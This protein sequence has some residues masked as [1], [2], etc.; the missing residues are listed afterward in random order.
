MCPSPDHFIGDE[1]KRTMASAQMLHKFDPAEHPGN[2]YDAFCEYVE[3]FAYE[4]EAIAKAP[5]AGTTDVAGW[6]A[7]DKRRQLLGRFASRN[8]QKDFED[9][10]VEGQ[11]ATLTFEQTVTL[12]KARYK[13]TQNKTVTNYDFHKLKQKPTETF[14]SW[15]NRVKHEAKYCD[16]ACTSNTCTVRDTLI[17]DQVIIGTTDNEI[18]RCALKEEWSLADLQSSGRKIEAAA[19]GAAKIKKEATDGDVR[20]T[21]PGK[22]SR[23]NAKNKGKG[24]KNCSNPN[25][26]GGEKVLRVRQR[27][28]RLQAKRT[29][30]GRR[31]LPWEASYSLQNRK[32]EEEEKEKREKRAVRQRLQQQQQQQRQFG[33]VIG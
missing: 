19:A 24:C 13:P 16:F 25:C 31:K 21:K 18:R 9:E 6:I 17:R 1:I 22:Y 15:V 12:L 8:L 14:D 26:E 28:F 10:T 2:T 11:R 7:V 29:S 20:R 23:K 30:Q 33:N 27:M 32:R 3:S 4:Y 5:P